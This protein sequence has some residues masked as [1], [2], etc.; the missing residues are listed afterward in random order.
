MMHA[1]L[2]LED[3]EP[4]PGRPFRSAPWMVAAFQT[5]GYRYEPQQTQHQASG[6]SWRTWR[7][8]E[9][10]PGA[11]LESDCASTLNHQFEGKGEIKMH[12]AHPF[13]IA[14]FAAR[15]HDILVQAQQNGLECGTA[16]GPESAGLTW[17][18]LPKSGVEHWIEG[19]TVVTKSLYLAAALAAVGFP[20]HSWTVDGAVVL[21]AHDENGTPG[22][23]T[24]SGLTLAAAT[25][26][27]TECAETFAKANRRESGDQPVPPTAERLPDEH[28]VRWACYGI[29]H[30]LA[31]AQ[32]EAQLEN[33]KDARRA[34][35]FTSGQTD[36]A[37]IVNWDEFHANRER[38]A[39]HLT[40]AAFA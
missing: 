1:W 2:T 28:I 9:R 27:A 25:A 14:Y 30:R 36:H 31:I 15:N 3:P 5:L 16:S 37:A 20:F 39:N 24:V 33:A 17:L 34:Y 6:K 21:R 11:S 23:Y 18:T 10:P 40:A 32:V 4:T 35:L 19:K 26:A 12:P 38:I 7:I 29:L 22:S 8:E 13:R